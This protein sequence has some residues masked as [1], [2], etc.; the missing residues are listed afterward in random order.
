MGVERLRGLN[1]SQK[2]KLLC[3][4]GKLHECLH[5]GDILGDTSEPVNRPVVC[6]IAIAELDCLGLDEL[7]AEHCQQLLAV[8]VENLVL[9]FKFLPGVFIPPTKGSFLIETIYRQKLG[10]WRN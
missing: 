5:K 4:T 7:L 10:G 6:S 2:P 9:A 1:L 8:A 3:D